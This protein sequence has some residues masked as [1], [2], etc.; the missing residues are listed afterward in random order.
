MNAAI[1]LVIILSANYNDNVSDVTSWCF[2]MDLV[3]YLARI[4]AIPWL[5]M[6]FLH[7]IQ[8]STRMLLF[9]ET[10]P[11]LSEIFLLTTGV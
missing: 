11:F 1:L 7:S 9:N 6:V 8:V 3:L 2:A 4:P 10:Q 5:F